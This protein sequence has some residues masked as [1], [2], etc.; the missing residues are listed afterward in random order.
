MLNIRLR[1][2]WL[3]GLSPEVR[4]SIDGRLI[5]ETNFHVGGFMKKFGL[6]ILP[7]LL[8]GA[9]ALPSAPATAAIFDY[10]GSGTFFNLVS[11]DVQSFSGSFTFD[12]GSG[13]ITS[14]SFLAGELGSFTQVA[15]NDT[16][17]SPQYEIVLFNATYQLDL[18]LDTKMTL[19]IGEPTVVDNATFG[20]TSLLVDLLNG[21][22]AGLD[23]N[24]TFNVSAVPEPSTWAMLILGFAG[25]SFMAYRRKSTSALMA[26]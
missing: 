4:A 20:K 5:C 13:R 25:I 22:G 12:T 8:L 18:I 21:D 6:S 16:N 3:H 17:S 11:E 14:P 7:A 23:I 26:A 10:S 15:S 19:A 2:S 1:R 9:T 24:A